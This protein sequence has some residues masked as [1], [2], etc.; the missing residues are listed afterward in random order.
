VREEEG[1]KENCLLEEENFGGS[2]DIAKGRR[3][4]GSFQKQIEGGLNEEEGTYLAAVTKSIHF[5]KS[6]LSSIGR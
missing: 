6:A 3:E 4:S 5:V 2:V 1:K